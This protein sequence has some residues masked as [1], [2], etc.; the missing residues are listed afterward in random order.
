MPFRSSDFSLTL[1]LALKALPYGDST[2]EC[3]PYSLSLSRLRS[4]ILLAAQE[5]IRK[6]ARA[7]I[8]SYLA[9]ERAGLV[10]YRSATFPAN[11]RPTCAVLK[12]DPHYLGKSLLDYPD[13][14]IPDVPRG[15]DGLPLEEREGPQLKDFQLTGLNWLAYCWSRCENGILADEVRTIAPRMMM[16]FR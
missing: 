11:R 16:V 1:S 8:D 7:E 12:A 5:D 3:K 13:G 2:W 10:P 15:P 14:V 4:P 6:I 9:R